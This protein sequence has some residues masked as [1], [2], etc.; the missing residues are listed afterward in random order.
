MSLTERVGAAMKSMRLSKGLDADEFGKA[1]GV[2]MDTV[3]KR[4]G[5]RTVLTFQ[6]IEDSAEALGRTPL[7]LLEDIVQYMRSQS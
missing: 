7:G 6:N 2:K 4:E 1:S 3:Y 5:G